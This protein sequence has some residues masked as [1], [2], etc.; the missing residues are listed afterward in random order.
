MLVNES[1]SSPSAG[2]ALLCD[3]EGTVLRWLH[4]DY[5]LRSDMPEGINF[6]RLLDESNQPKGLTFLSQLRDGA[7]LVGW[8]LC[9]V[10]RDELRVLRVAAACGAR[11]NTILAAETTAKLQSMCRNV[12]ASFSDCSQACFRI[13]S[14][15]QL[16]SAAV[17]EVHVQEDFMRIYNDFARLQREHAG[18]KA[19]LARLGVEKDRVMNMAVHDLRSPLSVIVLLAASVSHEARERLTERE[20]DLLRKVTHTAKDMGRA[21][22]DMLDRA[23][24][25]PGAPSLSPKH[26]DFRQLVQSRVDLLAPLATKKEIHLKLHCEPELPVIAFDSRHMQHV[27]DNLLGNAFK[28]SP[29]K[30]SVEVRLQPALQGLQMDV[31]DEGPGVPEAELDQIFEAY[32]RGS[33]TATGGEA[34]NGLGLSICRSIINAHGGRIWAENLSSG[35]AVFRVFLPDRSATVR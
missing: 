28:F 5:G 10:V 2:L 34:S 8:E 29:P 20:L 15:W 19:Q 33:A 22:G 26:G 9:F 23:R 1:K 3:C 4:D 16:P 14:A 27:V 24:H 17:S 31:C 6:L 30:A 12:G 32:T 25:A 11:T 7:A 35:G 13:L 18:Q 21:L